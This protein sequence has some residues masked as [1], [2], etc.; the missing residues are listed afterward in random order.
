[1]TLYIMYMRAPFVSS[2][3]VAGGWCSVI[4][5]PGSRF[6]SCAPRCG[7]FPD[8]V[9]Y[10]SNT[11]RTRRTARKMCRPLQ[12]PK[13]VGSHRTPQGT[14]LLKRPTRSKI[15]F[16]VRIRMHVELLITFPASKAQGWRSSAASIPLS[17]EKE[18]CMEESPIG[19]CLG[20]P[21][22][23]FYCT[24]PPQAAGKG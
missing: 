16:G 6:P 23:M 14:S 18:G 11:S 21:R 9:E 8:P 19:V 20:V 10:K 7:M 3:G 22:L 2:D 17:R 1:M 13:S 15:A 24:H 4:H 5:L 12:F